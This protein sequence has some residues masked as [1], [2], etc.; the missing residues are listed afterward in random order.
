MSHQ[1]RNT[2]PLS[3]FIHLTRYVPMIEN[4]T[5]PA[6]MEVKQLVNETVIASRKQLL[7]TGLYDENAMSPPK[8]KPKLKNI[9]VPASNQTTG[10]VNMYH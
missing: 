4:T 9:W 3:I 5:I 2:Y 1:L 7:L 6:N 10:S 8:A